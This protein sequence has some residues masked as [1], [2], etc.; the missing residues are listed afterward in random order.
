[1]LATLNFKSF[2]ARYLALT[3]LVLCLP[4]KPL[5]ALGQ[6]RRAEKRKNTE[7]F[8]GFLHDLDRVADR[9]L[10]E[11]QA[12][13][14]MQNLEPKAAQVFAKLSKRKR[15]EAEAAWQ[16]LE[17]RVSKREPKNSQSQNEKLRAFFVFRDHIYEDFR[18]VRSPSQVPDAKVGQNVYRTYCQSC[19]GAMGQGNGVLVAQARQPMQPAPRDLADL[20]SKELRNPFSVYNLLLVGKEGTTKQSYAAILSN[21]ELWSVSF[22]LFSRPFTGWTHK[23]SSDSELPLDELFPLDLRQLASLSDTEIRSALEAAKVSDPEGLLRV[24][25]TELAFSKALP[26]KISW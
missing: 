16:D 19:H 8:R 22:W 21:Q 20:M 9:L 7:L 1:M 6:D 3:L 14:Q 13:E 10:E 11:G 2:W 26:R 23:G 15:L 17:R 5:A 4:A 24:L 18:V 25:R 12:S